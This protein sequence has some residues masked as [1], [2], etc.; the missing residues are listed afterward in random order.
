MP[1][2]LASLTCKPSLIGQH[3][4]Y[5]CLRKAY[6]ATINNS[7][8][9]KQALTPSYEGEARKEMGHSEWRPW[10]RWDQ[11]RQM[12]EAQVMPC[13]QSRPTSLSI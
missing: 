5:R 3:S 6:A 1:E 10:C 12:M 7:F 13:L 8:L 11:I 4:G 9:Q 2:L